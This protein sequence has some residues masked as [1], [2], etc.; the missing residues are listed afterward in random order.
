MAVARN[1]PAAESDSTRR[2]A[3]RL[4]QEF[5]KEQEL[6]AYRSMLLIRRFE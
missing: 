6:Q 2:A 5:S 4:P 3:D 1:K